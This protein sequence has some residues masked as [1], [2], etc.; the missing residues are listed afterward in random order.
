MPHKLVVFWRRLPMNSMSG[1]AIL[2]AV[3]LAGVL[4]RWMIRRKLSEHLRG[5]AI[6]KASTSPLSARTQARALDQAYTVMGPTTI[7][8]IEDKISTIDD[9]GNR[10]IVIR[11]RTMETVL[12]P[13]G[14]TEV[15]RGCRLTL[16]GNGPVI[17]LS[18]T[19]FE[20]FRDR[21]RLKLD[22]NV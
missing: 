6:P 15:V 18:S 14:P 4:V 8:E 1:F 11:I 9:H 22:T 16:P 19:E 10:R 7:R 13:I 3:V 12:G 5:R 2:I 17:P 20:V 21:T